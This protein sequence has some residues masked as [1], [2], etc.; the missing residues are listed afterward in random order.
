MNICPICRVGRLR[1]R[2]MAYIEWLGRSLLIADKMP[3]QICDVCGERFYDDLAIENLQ[4]LLWS[5]SAR[6]TPIITRNT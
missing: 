6:S 5:E 4:H 1:Q 2:T 3:V